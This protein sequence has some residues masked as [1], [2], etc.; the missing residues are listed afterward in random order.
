LNDELDSRGATGLGEHLSGFWLARPAS[1]CPVTRA[2]VEKRLTP[3]ARF[4]VRD[5]RIVA[6]VQLI[7]NTVAGCSL[8]TGRKE[9]SAAARL[10]INTATVPANGV[11]HIIR[12]GYP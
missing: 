10:T 3:N 9:T 11:N 5:E 2:K 4:G 7:E 6:D 8:T 12:K 1:T